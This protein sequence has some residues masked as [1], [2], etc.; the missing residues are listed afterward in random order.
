MTAAPAP[1]PRTTLARPGLAALSWEG[2]LDAAAYRAPRTLR[3][4]APAAALRDRPADAGRQRDQ[5]LFGELFDVLEVEDGW[6]FGQARRD[7]YVGHVEA[8]LLGEPGPLATHRVGRPG[9]PA[10][11]QAADAADPVLTLDLNALVHVAE[12]SG[13][14][15]RV[16]GLGWMACADLADFLSFETDAASVAERFAGAPYASGGRGLDGIDAAGL[17]QQALYACGRACPREPDQQAAE[18]GVPTDAPRRGD[19][20][21]WADHIGLMLDDRRLVHADPAQGCVMLEPVSEAA[22]RRGAPALYLR[23]F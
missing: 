6:A 14:R 12:V 19:L 16:D 20:A 18:L 5:L 3:C 8:R 4:A 17:V 7:G 23:P 1:D 13:A 15:A 9:A 11:S 2:V 10:W 22:D 21:V